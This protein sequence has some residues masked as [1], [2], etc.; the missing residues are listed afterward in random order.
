MMK[1]AIILAVIGIMTGG[2]LWQVKDTFPTPT[3]S[4][5]GHC[6]VEPHDQGHFGY[7]CTTVHSGTLKPDQE[8]CVY[9]ENP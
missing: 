7:D 9:R 8:Y 2:I 1:L 5:V 4:S 3:C 6:P